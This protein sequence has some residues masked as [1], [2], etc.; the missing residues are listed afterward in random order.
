MKRETIRKTHEKRYSSNQQWHASRIV[1]LLGGIRAI[2]IDGPQVR[3]K[4]KTL[5]GKITQFNTRS[6][7]AI[8]SDI[9]QL[10][11]SVQERIYHPLPSHG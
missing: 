8:F 10:G 11:F 5:H 7:G 1:H 9:H 3:I 2:N 4:P 6:Y